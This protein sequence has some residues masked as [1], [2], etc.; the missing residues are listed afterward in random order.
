MKN[1]KSEFLKI[2]EGRDVSCAEITSDIADTAALKTGHSKDDLNNFLQEIDYPIIEGYEKIDG[3]VWFKDGTWAVVENGDWK[4][5]KFPD[6]PKYL[7]KFNPS[8]KC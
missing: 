5:F 2:S 1:T 6:I 4:L 8:K 3:Q 7:W